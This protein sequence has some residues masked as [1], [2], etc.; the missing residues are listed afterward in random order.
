MK[1]KLTL[2][3]KLTITLT[4]LSGVVVLVGAGTLGGTYNSYSNYQL[5]TDMQK[6]INGDPWL[7]NSSNLDNLTTQIEKE[8]QSYSY[9]VTGKSSDPKSNDD[10]TI[11]YN[12]NFSLTYNFS[13]INEISPSGWN[14]KYW[15]LNNNKAWN[16]NYKESQNSYR[17]TLKGIFQKMFP[18]YESYEKF[19]VN[20]ASTLSPGANSKELQSRSSETYKLYNS[21]YSLNYEFDASQGGVIAGS[22]VLIVG[23]I[24]FITM[25]VIIFLK[26]KKRKKEINDVKIDKINA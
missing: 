20:N 15:G 9:S 17:S 16:D 25:L 21:L 19:F 13:S 6:T 8:A 26:N 1:K 2:T 18:S 14:S 22:V 11:S 7:K 10:S 24:A 4:T 23:A 3:K 5:L 12:Y